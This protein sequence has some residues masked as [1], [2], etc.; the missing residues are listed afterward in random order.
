MDEFRGGGGEVFTNCCDQAR[1]GVISKSPTR[2]TLVHPHLP[3]AAETSALGTVI[4]FDDREA[5]LLE[6]F[7]E[8]FE[9]S[10]VVEEPLVVGE[11]LF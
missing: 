8:L 11:L 1:R 5:Q 2:Q 6:L 3:E 4:C 9:A 7:Q 10:V